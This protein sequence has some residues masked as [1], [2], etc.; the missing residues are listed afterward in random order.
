MSL[1]L[2][3]LQLLVNSFHNTILYLFQGMKDVAIGKNETV[4]EDTK[5]ESL[6]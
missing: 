4:Q 1:K 5:A 6:K 3:N 2:L